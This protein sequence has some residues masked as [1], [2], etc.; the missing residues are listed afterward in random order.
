MS[1]YGVEIHAA[2]FVDEMPVP[3]LIESGL[4]GLDFLPSVCLDGLDGLNGTMGLIGLRHSGQ[5]V[6]L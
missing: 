5:I 4:D 1:A 3:V 6:R 2:D